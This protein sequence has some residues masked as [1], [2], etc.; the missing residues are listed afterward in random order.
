LMFVFELD[1]E[2][3]VRKQLRHDPRKFQKFFLCH[4]LPSASRVRMPDQPARKARNL[5]ES[6]PS[7]NWSG[8][9]SSFVAAPAREK[10]HP[11]PLQ[12][13]V[14]HVS[15][16]LH[17]LLPAAVDRGRIGGGPVLD[18]ERERTR[19]L[20]RLVMRFGRERDDEVEIETLQILEL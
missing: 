7:D 4:P 6:G 16:R 13:L 17:A 1:P 11:D 8:R 15:V 9:L 14:A 18:V 20:K 10:A 3:G 5:A 2:S 19:E 12:Q